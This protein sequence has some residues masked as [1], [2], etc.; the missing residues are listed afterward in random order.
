M[1]FH[2][3]RLKLGFTQARA[4]E[5]LKLSKQT[6]TDYDK[7]RKKIKPTVIE[8]MQKIENEKKK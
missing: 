3:W 1:D 5:V 8:L 4:K 7:G 6:V 2:K